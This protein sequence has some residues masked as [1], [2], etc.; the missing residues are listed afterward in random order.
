MVLN[1]GGWMVVVT[2]TAMDRRCSGDG[3]NDG[4]K[5]MVVVVMGGYMKRVIFH[6]RDYYG[7]GG[8]RGGHRLIMADV[9]WGGDYGE[10][11]CPGYKRIGV[12]GYR[13]GDG[14]HN[15]GGVAM[16]KIMMAK[17]DSNRDCQQE[18]DNTV[19][20]APLQAW[21]NSQSLI[22]P[23]SCFSRV[24]INL[25]LAFMALIPCKQ[26]KRC[27]FRNYLGEILKIKR[28]EIQKSKPAVNFRFGKLPEETE[29]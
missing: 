21:M 15:I 9:W 22:S 26:E 12:R 27:D 7:C 25:D 29:S 16:M 4:V 24:K 13:R 14:F 1:N 19:T 3:Y 6:Y 17:N 23:S 2:A 10:N 18:P 11:S 20:S 8:A 28:N 5:T